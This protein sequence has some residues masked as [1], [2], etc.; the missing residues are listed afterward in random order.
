MLSGST[1]ERKMK[2]LDNFGAENLFE[3]SKSTKTLRARTFCEIF[4]LQSEDF[5]KIVYSQCDEE[6]V[7]KM[8]D[9]AEF[10]SKNA[11]KVNKLFGSADD[12]VPTK[13]FL[14]H[15]LPNSFFRY[16]WD[17]VIFV[18]CIFYYFSV[19]LKV[20]H[21]L[22]GASF[23]T[24]LL[25]FTL[26]YIWDVCFI[27]DILLNFNYFMHFEEGLLVSDRQSIR[28]K[29]R[30]EHNLLIEC[31][32]SAP[33]D[34]L[35]VFNSRW[36]FLLRLSKILRLPQ[37]IASFT[38]LE[39]LLSDIKLEKGMLFLKIGKL[40][41]ALIITCHWIGCL[42]HACAS[43]SEILGMEN[44]W[45]KEDEEDASL[46]IDHSQF[47]GFG[48]YLRSIYW[49]LVGTS[50]VGYGDIV[51]TN[52]LETAF[53]TVFILFGGLILPAIVGKFRLILS[54]MFYFR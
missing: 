21:Y 36:C 45:L 12:N 26:S 3:K 32:A 41:F 10:M 50:T 15:C 46:S 49:A 25:S 14:R 5:K 18:G 24:H 4:L 47:R 6:M 13:G 40:N 30:R 34:I 1:L 16:A 22:D 48:P 35:G 23:T 53:A 29:F 52:I 42:W 39:R 54:G 9:T 33:V 11:S 44:N 8:R 38:K 51:P 43:I 20:M 17:L 7:K 31:I 27:L 19:P 37:V 28:Q 2:R